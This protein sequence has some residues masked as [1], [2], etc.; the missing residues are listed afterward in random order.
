MKYLVAGICIAIVLMRNVFP[1]MVFDDASLILVIIALVVLIL[2]DTEQMFERLRR[3]KKGDIELEFESSI[4]KLNADLTEAEESADSAVPRAPSAEA[5]SSAASRIIDQASR[6]PR[7]AVL[8]LAIEIEQ[9]VRALVEESDITLPRRPLSFH[10]MLELLVSEE[11]V[12]RDVLDLV[13]RFWRVRSNVVHG[14]RFELTEGQL[15]EVL[16]IGIRILK[17][18][19]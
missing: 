2:P 9:A 1:A 3:I 17:L 12:S 10:R 11:K 18:L 6:D 7:G 4:A 5:I 13:K 16:E 8:I 15:Y 14:V 19:K